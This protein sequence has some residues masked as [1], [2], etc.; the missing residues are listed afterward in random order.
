MMVINGSAVEFAEIEIALVPRARAIMVF[1][2]AVVNIIVKLAFI[3]WNRNLV[4]FG[5]IVILNAIPFGITIDKIAVD[6]GVTPRIATGI[7]G[8]S[9]GISKRS[10]EYFFNSSAMWFPVFPLTF[11]TR[12]PFSA[13]K[14]PQ[15]WIVWLN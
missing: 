8:L 2:H 12:Q 11:I 1:A 5:D 4:G 3:I 13:A 6:N 15:I 9:F 10:F 7:A 14:V